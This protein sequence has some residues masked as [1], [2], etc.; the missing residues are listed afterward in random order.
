MYTSEAMEKRR[1]LKESPH[2][3][4]GVYRWWLFLGG[5]EF[6]LNTG[7][8]SKQNYVDMC[9]LTE[10]VRLRPRPS[11]LFPDEDGSLL[12]VL[13]TKGCP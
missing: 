4:H 12:G 5:G 1:R 9:T 11:S 2:V 6:N 7:F 13:G 3:I 8:I 10:Q